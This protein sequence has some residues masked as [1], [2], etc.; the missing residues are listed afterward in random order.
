LSAQRTLRLVATAPAIALTV[1]VAVSLAACQAANDPTGTPPE[2]GGTPLALAPPPG[3]FVP[4]EAAPVIAHPN[5]LALL[6][7]D[8]PALAANKRLLFDMWR[9]VLNAGHLEVADELVAEDY[10]Q[11]SP[12]Q[13]S[14]R[15]ALKDVFSV[16]PRRDEIPA[17]M[18][19]PPVTI[20]AEDDFVVFVAVEE[21]PEPDGSGSY[22]TTHFNLFRVANGRLSEHWHPDQTPPCPDLPSAANGGPQPVTGAAS[23]MQFALL[24]AELPALARNKRLVFD[25]WRHLFDAGREELVELYLSEDYVEHN[26]NA[27]SGRDGAR[28]WFAGVEDRPIPTALGSDL[29][30]MIAEGD[31]VVQVLKLE[32]PNPWRPGDRFTTTRIDMFRIADGQIAEHWNASVKPGTVVEELGA[33]CAESAA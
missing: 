4:G 22:T 32:L 6:H 13:R 3:P 27:A 18:R 21:M 2:A 15:Q 20:L 9:T 23:N 29:V 28:A 26:P 5:Q 33:A 11:H 14:G 7:N 1:L 19:P 12:F 30:A 16:I 10:I 8:D 31:L 25:A 24:A 17:E